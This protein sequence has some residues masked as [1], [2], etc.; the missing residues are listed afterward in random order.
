[1]ARKFGKGK[2]TKSQSFRKSQAWRY[3]S[4]RDNADNFEGRTVLVG[5]KGLDLKDQPDSSNTNANNDDKDK[6]DLQLHFVKNTIK[7]SKYTIWTFIPRCGICHDYI[8]IYIYIYIKF[9]D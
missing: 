8:Y 9:F 1:M 3:L 4:R 2:S 5:G 6:E 7:S